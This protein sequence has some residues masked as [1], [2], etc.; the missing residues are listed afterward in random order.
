MWNIVDYFLHWFDLLVYKFPHRFNRQKDTLEYT[1]LYPLAQAHAWWPPHCTALDLAS[2]VAGH[3]TVAV[4]GCIDLGSTAH[5]GW[6]GT[7][8]LQICNFVI[9]LE[10]KIRV[11]SMIINFSFCCYSGAYN[12]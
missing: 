11:E 4:C 10:F 5:S 3:S 7:Y 2:C 8:Q 6:M 12:C 1:I 9:A